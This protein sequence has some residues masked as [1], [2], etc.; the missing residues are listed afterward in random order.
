MKKSDDAMLG[1]NHEASK[2]SG[3]DEMFLLDLV[4]SPQSKRVAVKIR[5]FEK[6]R[7]VPSKAH[8]RRT[9]A[10]NHIVK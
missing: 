5:S 8:G 7:G 2:S 6:A 3:L 4:R 10:Y 9:G 1:T